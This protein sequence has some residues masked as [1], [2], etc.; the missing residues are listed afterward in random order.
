[1][2]T[3]LAW[4]KPLC[5]GLALGFFMPA[6]AHVACAEPPPTEEKIDQ[7]E[8][9]IQAL[10]QA[11]EELRRAPQPAGGAP[12]EDRAAAQKRPLPAEQE[13]PPPDSAYTNRSTSRSAGRR[14]NTNDPIACI[15]DE[16][17]NRSQVME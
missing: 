6:T 1:M 3:A 11:V 4:A 15:R 8:K 10:K 13:T 14:G 12:L 7:I 9:Q 5:A 17:L 2:K 16:G